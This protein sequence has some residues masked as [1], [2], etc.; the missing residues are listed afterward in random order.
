MTVAGLDEQ[1]AALAT[2][3]LLV[4]AG[5]PTD[6]RSREHP[7]GW[8]IGASVVALLVY[9]AAAAWM[10]YGMRYEIGD[11]ISR[12]ADARAM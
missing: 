1:T 3:D 7:P 9:L 12:T 10:Y 4:S 6:R 11:A 2:A 8:E 5:T